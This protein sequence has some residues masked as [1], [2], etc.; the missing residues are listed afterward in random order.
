MGEEKLTAHPVRPPFQN[1]PARTGL[2]G[3]E[4]PDLSIR[5]PSRRPSPT[6]VLD[7][8]AP[9]PR[10]LTFYTRT[11]LSSTSI[12]CLRTMLLEAKYQSDIRTTTSE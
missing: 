6:R 10:S 12:H 7:D 11:A 3:S 2:K 8:I 5:Y 1:F 4:Y 9:V